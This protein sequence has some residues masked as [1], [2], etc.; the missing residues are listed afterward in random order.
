MRA[1]P[2]GATLASSWGL[3]ISADET[4]A[5]EGRLGAFRT[6]TRRRFFRWSLRGLGG[7]VGLAGAASGGLLALRGCAPDVPGLRVLSAH[8]YRTLAHLARTIIPAGGPFPEGA[9]DFDLARAFDG[10]LESEP[11]ENVDALGDALTLFE[12][13][14]VLFDG[15]LKTFSN[16][17]PDDQ[18][19]HVEGWMT[20]ERLLRR[21]VATA[22]RRFVCLVFY[23]QPAI[24][25]H[26][27]Y[28][29]PSAG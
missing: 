20:S 15:R 21:Q 10:F 19:T 4:T 17:P 23:D 22:F 6:L 28:G 1:A 26:I 24:W 13:G 12:L 18:L 16:L 5:G 14:P 8:Q 7:L 27:G 9:D 29:G 2:G 25:P 11:E 3:P